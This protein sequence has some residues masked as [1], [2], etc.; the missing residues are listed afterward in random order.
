MSPGNGQEIVILAKQYTVQYRSAREQC[1]ILEALT[2]IF[3]RRYHIDA[4]PP[5]ASGDGRF[6]MDIHVQAEH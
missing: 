4:P 2:P 5:H 1:S 6:D 3:L